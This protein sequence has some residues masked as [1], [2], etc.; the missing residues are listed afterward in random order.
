MRIGIL[1]RWNATCGVSMHAELIGRELIKMGCELVVFAPYVE[2][3]NKWWHHRVIRRDEEFVVRC[4]TETEP[5]KKHGGSIDEEKILSYNPDFLIVESYVSIPYLEVERLVRRMNS[6]TVA[7]IHE[8]RRSDILYS[9]LQVFDA[10][11]VFDERYLKEML[12]DHED[13]VRIIP[14]PC[15]RIRESKR[16]FA[17]DQLTFFTFGRQPENEY[18]DYLQALELIHK[19]HDFIYKVIRSDGALSF[20]KPWLK[21]LKKRLEDEELY[22][23]LSKSDV[24]LLPKGRTDAVVVS[25][26]L[27]QCLG[28]LVPTVVPDTRHFEA[29]PREKPVITYNSVDNLTEELEKLIEDEEYR[30]KIKN[31]AKRYVEENSSEKIARKLTELLNSV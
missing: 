11:A 20:K 9:N 8:G 1:S 29:L 10:I 12:K 31:A 13:L 15:H 27:S 4:Y 3:A 19:K 22:R 30:K 25:S 18:R 24:H 7:V 2:S 14:Y 26:T 21:E 23:E 16:K 28:S 5:G 6:P 17:E